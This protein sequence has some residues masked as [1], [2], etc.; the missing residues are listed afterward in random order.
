MIDYTLIRSNRKTA[1]IYVRSDGVE[2]RAPMRM[3]GHVIDRFVLSKEQWIQDKIAIM[4]GR[5][6]DRESFALDYGSVILYIG[7]LFPI[8][9]DS[10]GFGFDGTCFRLPPDLSPDQIK[11]ACIGI[12]RKLAEDV[13]GPR[14][15][16][17]A[18]L[19]SLSF[20]SVTITGAQKQ[21]GSCTA[22]KRLNFSWRLVLADSDLIDYVIVHELAHTVELNHS[23][24][25]WAIVEGVFPDYRESKKRLR[26]L[27]E[28]LA[29]ENWSE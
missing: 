2:V 8:V 15:V 9:A 24:R 6:E 13:I 16:E 26:S 7:K 5:L 28:R 29:N 4:R 19:M 17:F 1:A 10:S 25:F 11:S 3:P 20:A 12:Y 14:T 23:A 22:K 21:W 18:D 27:H